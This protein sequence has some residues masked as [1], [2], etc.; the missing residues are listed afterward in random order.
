MNPVR[1]TAIDPRT[2]FV[3]KYETIDWRT[4]FSIVAVPTAVVF[5]TLSLPH[6][7]RS[8]H[9]WRVLAHAGPYQVPDLVRAKIW[10]SSLEL[11]DQAELMGLTESEISQCLTDIEVVTQRR[12]AVKRIVDENGFKIFSPVL[13]YLSSPPPTGCKEKGQSM[14]EGNIRVA[15]DV[16]TATPA[17]Q[18]AV[19]VEVIEDLVRNNKTQWESTANEETMRFREYRMLLLLKL[20]QNPDN[21][22]NACESKIVRDFIESEKPN[23]GHVKF[24][25]LPLMPLLYQFKTTKLGYEFSDII[26]RIETILG[27][28][29]PSPAP[30]ESLSLPSKVDFANFEKLVYLTLCYSSLR[31]IPLITEY[32]LPVL[33][34]AGRVMAKSVLG[35]ALLETVYRAVEHVIQSR[36]YYES[37]DQ[38]GAGKFISSGTLVGAQAICVA[39]IL[40]RFPY[41][42]AP[43]ALMKLRD[44]F[45]DSFRFI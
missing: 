22:K 20:L 10:K 9:G 23:S 6:D 4:I 1:E 39:V 3:T 2:R 13:K 8:V 14:F 18:R 45:V 28:S 12:F 31:V 26:E 24:S 42:F 40:K 33:S 35:A 17:D 44:S 7:V 41:C 30:R 27:T 19:P 32:S 36:P 37:A 38:G 25:C 5:V 29:P 16:V 34:G 43:F 11:L 15:M 21:A